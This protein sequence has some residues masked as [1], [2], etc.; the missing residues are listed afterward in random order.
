MKELPGFRGGDETR[1]RLAA[2]SLFIVVYAGLTAF[3][4]QSLSGGSAGELAGIR[5]APGAEPP[6]RNVALAYG[7]FF[8]DGERFY[9]KGVGWDP[10]RPGE[11]P[12]ER[13]FREDEVRDDFDRIRAGGF[14]TVR[15]WA[16]MRPEELALAAKAD[17]KVVQGIWVEPD[18]DF[19]DPAF[20]EETLRRVA[21]EVK[22]SR[23]SP[24]IIAYLVINEPRATAVAAA[25]LD[26]TRSFL[27]EVAATVRALDPSAPIGYASWPGMEGLDDELFDFTAFNLYPH[28]PVVVMDE[29]GLPG[30][31]KLLRERVARGRPLLVS[32]FGLSVSPQSTVPG[33]GGASIEEQANGLCALAEAHR[34]GGAAGSVVFQ[35]SDG[36]WKNADGPD[37][38]I[39]HDPGDP[40][41]W[42][43]LVEFEGLDDRRGNARPAL[44][45]LEKCQ[46]VL[47][48][49]PLSGSVSPPEI[50]VRILAREPID[51][52]VRVD[53][54]DPVPLTLSQE[55]SWWNGVIPFPSERERGR[56]SLGFLA[57]SRTGET[58]FEEQRL[59]AVAGGRRPFE[60]EPARISV[61]PGGEYT[62][63]IRGTPKAA[64][65]V[66]SF[67]EDR[68]EEDRRRIV[69]DGSGAG[70]VTF[71]APDAP[72]L[73]TVLVFE[74]DSGIPSAER[75]A[76]FVTVEVRR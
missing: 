68:P 7:A 45:A 44:A 46:R 10:A 59:L 49:E 70:R 52:S 13:V 63:R 75:E 50:P 58:M 33:R 74:N 5:V 16:A 56:I 40:E 9:V 73:M 48:T 18:G 22:E 21:R 17:L 27:R 53:G 60:I 15:T 29:L 32:E 6:V 3:F 36:W 34:L 11:M 2:V 38:A 37:D 54:S 42:F 20:R 4:Y 30:Y 25:G 66:A 24:A 28:R 14:N 47:L 26:A 31:V 19:A 1:R 41:E 61:A 43:G 71:Q 57:R 64:V 65:G 8:V 69:L 72:T 35:W 23:W 62:I 76:G 39:T 51:L 55:G 12:W 67:T